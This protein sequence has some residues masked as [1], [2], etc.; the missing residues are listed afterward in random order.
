MAAFQS[1]TG[2]LVIRSSC[3][4]ELKLESIREADFP[5]GAPSRVVEIFGKVSVGRAW[6]QVDR[7]ETRQ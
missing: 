7:T 5:V 1:M 6:R 2:Y 3:V 4:A